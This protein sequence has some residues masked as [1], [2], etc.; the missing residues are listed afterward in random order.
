MQHI[1]L[2]ISFLQVRGHQRV[3]SDT[4]EFH[5]VTKRDALRQL[6]K[7]LDNLLQTAPEEKKAFLQ[8]EMKRF[9]QLFERFLQEGGQEITRNKDKCSILIIFCRWTYRMG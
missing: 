2:I 8:N 7:E 3:P 1:L 9:T 4:K 6:E 5:E